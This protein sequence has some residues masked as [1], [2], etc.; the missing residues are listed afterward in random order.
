MPRYDSPSP[1]MANIDR[2]AL[3]AAVA[4]FPTSSRPPADLCDE[5][6]RI[7]REWWKHSHS[8]SS[9]DPKDWPGQRIMDSRTSHNRRRAEWL[10]KG[11]EQLQ[12]IERICRTGTSPQCGP[13]ADRRRP[14]VQAETQEEVL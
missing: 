10:T 7:W 14:I 13:A 8:Y 12:L 1:A 11:L 5:H 2:D 6:G 4:A 9:L 3:R